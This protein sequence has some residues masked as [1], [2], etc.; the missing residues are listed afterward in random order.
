IVIAV[1][2]P[3]PEVSVT[4][5]PFTGIERI[6]VKIIMKNHVPV[7][8]LALR[9]RLRARW[10]APRLAGREEKRQGHQQQKNSQGRHKV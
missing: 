6:A 1:I 7:A 10:S 3:H 9:Q 8:R 5:R 4:G 2:F